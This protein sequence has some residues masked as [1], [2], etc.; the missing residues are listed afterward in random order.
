[1]KT[2]I[3]KSNVGPPNHRCHYNSAFNLQG[4]L[5]MENACLGCCAASTSYHVTD[6][7]CSEQSEI[8]LNI[9]RLSQAKN[10]VDDL[11]IGYQTAGMINV[12]VKASDLRKLQETVSSRSS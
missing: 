9:E 4:M 2:P 8:L 11:T 7:N 10:I 12:V 3:E 1:M 6:D 5:P